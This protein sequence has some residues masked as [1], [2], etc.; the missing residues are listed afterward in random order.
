MAL[1]MD[2][3]GTGGAVGYISDGEPVIPVGVSINA[4]PMSIKKKEWELYQQFAKDNDVYFL[5]EDNIPTVDFYAVPRVDVAATDSD[6]GLIASVGEPFD[7]CDSVPLVYISPSLECYL[8]TQDSAQ[9]LSIAPQWKKHLV[10]YYGVT[11][12]PSKEAAMEDF[13]IINVVDTLE[14]QE[15]MKMVEENKSKTRSK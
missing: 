9:F 8:I 12:Y 11:L 5:F 7:L 13:P 2:F 6:G 10:P 1:Y 14:Y 3:S 15:L 4:M